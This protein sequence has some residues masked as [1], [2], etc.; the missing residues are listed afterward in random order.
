MLKIF[1][2]KKEERLYNVTTAPQNNVY[3]NSMTKALSIPSVFACT[4]LIANT[5]SSLPLGVFVDGLK[6]EEHPGQKIIDEPIENV[7]TETWINT[8]LRNVLINGNSYIEITPNGLIIQDA[9]NVILLMDDMG[10][11][12][13]YQVG[14]RNVRKEDML[15]FKRLTKDERGQIGIS[16]QDTFSLLF[17]EIKNT[18]LHTSDYMEH[19]LTTGLWLSIKGKAQP[20]T[21]EKIR[22]AF[23]SLYQGVANRTTIPTLTDGMELNEIKNNTLK[24]SAID[25]LKTMQLKDVAMIFNVPI[26]LLDGS[27]GNYGSTVEANLMFLKSC[28]APLLRNIEAELNLKLNTGTGIEYKF[29][30]S[31]YLAGSFAQQVATLSTSVNSGL[32]TANEARERLGYEPLKD[33]N[34]LYI[35][36]G[37]P[38][39]Q[40]EVK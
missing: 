39:T 7:T 6:V 5:V 29:D 24:D 18:S 12:I 1:G 28:I 26:T 35:P 23:K 10:D 2:K 40:K 8:I 20:E 38:S 27:M 34:V 17:D 3:G 9:I 30:T 33:G 37:S 22:E 13:K 4:S 36:A 14:N 32:L 19:G 16:L 25:E 21:L 15:H 31:A 11:I